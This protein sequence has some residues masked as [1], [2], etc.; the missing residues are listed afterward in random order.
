MDE[1]AFTG[2]FLLILSGTDVP[3]YPLKGAAE[4]FC[5]SEKEK[6]YRFSEKSLS[7]AAKTATL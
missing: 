5:F 7:D 1:L 2:N 3:L 4:E 6:K